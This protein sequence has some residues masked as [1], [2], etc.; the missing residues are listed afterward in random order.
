MS[1]WVVLMTGQRSD[2]EVVAPGRGTVDIEFDG[3]PIL[4]RMWGEHDSSTVGL[5]STG[6][7]QAI[8]AT[9][10]DVMID[11]SGVSFMDASTI[12]CLARGEVLLQQRDRSLTVRSPSVIQ[13]K[14]LEI[15]QLA[16]LIET[17]LGQ[18][19]RA[20]ALESWVAIPVTP[21]SAPDPVE[22][23]RQ[24]VYEVTNLRGSS[25]HPEPLR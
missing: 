24:P 25:G 2:D 7:A 4:L 3:D 19:R 21:R 11:L 5:V 15:C 20:S 10:G 22:E 6:L 9:E 16:Y 8:D 18:A 12:A 17:P 13:R 1:G 23:E 14:L